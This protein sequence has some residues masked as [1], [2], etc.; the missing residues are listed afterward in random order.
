[1]FH[2]Y[3]VIS[4][5]AVRLFSARWTFKAGTSAGFEFG[6]AI[7]LEILLART[8]LLNTLKMKYV[9]TVIRKT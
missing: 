3:M 1:M 6:D 9:R 7:S 5:Q 2:L 4:C 8:A